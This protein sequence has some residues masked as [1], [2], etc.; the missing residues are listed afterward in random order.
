M[1]QALKSVTPLLLSVTPLLLLLVFLLTV[2]FGIAATGQTKPSEIARAS[3]PPIQ[4]KEHYV[5]RDSLR[6]YLWEKYK[7]GEEESFTRTGKV[8]LLVHGGQRSGRR[9]TTCRSTTI[10]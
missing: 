4:G 3:T 9:F 6:I 2:A 5:M 8:A 1:K 10:P 7:E